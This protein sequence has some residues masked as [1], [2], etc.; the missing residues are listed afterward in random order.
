MFFC[1]RTSLMF[2]FITK[3]SAMNKIVEIQ[4]IQ[5]AFKFSTIIFIGLI[6]L[7]ML[8]SRIFQTF[9][10]NN[11]NFWTHNYFHTKFGILMSNYLFYNARKFKAKIFIF[12]R[13]IEISL[14]DYF[15]LAHSVYGKL[16][17]KNASK[18]V[19]RLKFEWI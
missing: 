2:I 6:A 18:N 16:Y 5:C 14:G 8:F 3:S 10:E 11:H 12:C 1:H 7:I 9:Y 17:A 19:S 4:E 15:F 13:V